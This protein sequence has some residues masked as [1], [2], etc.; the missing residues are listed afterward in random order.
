LLAR[1]P[2]FPDSFA[3]LTGA[4]GQEELLLL[5]LAKARHVSRFIVSYASPRPP[6]KQAGVQGEPLNEGAD[7]LARLA[8]RYAADPCDLT[9][10]EYHRRADSLA[11]AFSKEF[12]RLQEVGQ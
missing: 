5:A 6:V 4:I 7:A 9:P 12:N 10:T 8:R 1:L 3:Y 2:A 11:E